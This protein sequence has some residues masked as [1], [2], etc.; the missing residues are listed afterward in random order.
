M[1]RRAGLALLAT[2]WAAGVG[3]QVAS[4]PDPKYH[5]V[6]SITSGQ[7]SIDRKLGTA[8]LAVRR[9]SI[10]LDT[11]ESNGI[12]PDQEPI[13]IALGEQQFYLEPGALRARRKGRSFS[14]RARVKPGNRGIARFRLKPLAET[15]AYSLRFTLVGADLSRLLFEDPVCLPMAVIVGDDD[16]FTGVAITSPSFRSRRL[17]IPDE[18]D[19]SDWPW[20]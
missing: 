18:C 15:G 9:W 5:G 1:R 19:A 8:T 11:R 14:Y 17:R 7:G 6:L 3:A 20:A 2:L 12:F 10:K 4:R 13:L 16:G